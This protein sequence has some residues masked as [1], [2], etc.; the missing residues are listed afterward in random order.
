MISAQPVQSSVKP[1]SSWRTG[2]SYPTATI[3]GPL[4]KLALDQL[5]ATADAGDG[6]DDEDS[7]T[8]ELRTFA[9]ALRNEL[10]SRF[11]GKLSNFERFFPNLKSSQQEPRRLARR[12]HL[13]AVRAA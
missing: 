11:E 5:D 6:D 13:R 8:V 10:A 4:V 12:V 2:S 7:V 3:R 9:R 1:H